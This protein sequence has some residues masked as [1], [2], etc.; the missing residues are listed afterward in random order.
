MTLPPPPTP[1]SLSSAS[2]PG[3]VWPIQGMLLPFV[4][5]KQD[6]PSLGCLG[7]LVQCCDFPKGHDF[8]VDKDPPANFCRIGVKLLG[9]ITEA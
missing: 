9:G 7:S 8:Y 1:A 6:K 5:T 3:M 2:Q 4:M